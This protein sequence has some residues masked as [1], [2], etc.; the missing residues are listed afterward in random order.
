[1]MPATD[2]F[3]GATFC[4]QH[5]TEN[6]DR[7]ECLPV[8]PD[9]PAGLPADELEDAAVVAQ[10]GREIDAAGVPYLLD[11]IIGSI[12]EPAA[13]PSLNCCSWSPRIGATA[14][15]SC[16]AAFCVAIRIASRISCCS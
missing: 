10:H 3:E 15:S 2:A 9:D 13:M 5:D 11:G 4:E 7:L 16:W 1:M 12:P 14:A 8:A 6:C